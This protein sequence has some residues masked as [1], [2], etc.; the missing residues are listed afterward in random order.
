[1][2]AIFTPSFAKGSLSAPPSKS[3]AHRALICAAFA[4]GESTISPIEFSEDIKATIA[5]LSELGAEFKIENNSVRVK[6]ILFPRPTGKELFCAESG[7]TLRFLIPICLITGEKIVLRG[8]KRLFERPLSIY[9]NLCKENGFLFEKT[10]DS[11]TLKGKLSAG[12]YRIPGDL[13]SQFITG[14]LFALSLLSEESRI[15]I[16]G[17]TESASYLDLTLSAMR[18]FGV[19]IQKEENAFL[20]PAKSVFAAQN[21]TVEGD[22]SN[23]AF[24]DAFTLLGGEVE[25]L[26]L[27]EDSMQ[28]DRI[29]REHFRALKA[30]FAEIDLADCPDLAPIL[31]ALAASFHGAKFLGTAR[32]RLKESDRG[33]AMKQEL[34]KCGV[35][36]EIKE[37]EILVPSGISAPKQSIDSHN[38]HRIAMAMSIILSRFGG[39]LRGAEA[40]RKSFPDYFDRIA[41]LGVKV[42][43]N[44]T[45]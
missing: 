26:G 8:A 31:F 27:K 6:G 12:S 11:L 17:K 19:E 10:E 33:E 5:S 1:M 7:S 34:A 18:D 32:L 39:T 20:I 21:F 14:L 42:T 37:N 28:G 29:Y 45:E 35:H 36:L 23:A 4:N 41:K 2:N 3:M 22:F 40:V 15:E 16:I 9:E 24:L 30:G 13:S 43:L 25:V 38:D 44:E